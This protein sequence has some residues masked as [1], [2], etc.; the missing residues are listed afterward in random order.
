MKTE[1]KIQVEKGPPLPTEIV[2]FLPIKVKKS[3]VYD[4]VFTDN[5]GKT[6]YFEKDGSYDGWSRNCN[7]S[8]N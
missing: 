4:L 2:I 7:Y 5:S 8:E 6:H 1:I 3:E